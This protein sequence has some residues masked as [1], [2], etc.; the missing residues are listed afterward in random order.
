MEANFAQLRPNRDLKPEVDCKSSRRVSHDRIVAMDLPNE[1]NCQLVGMMNSER[2]KI[3]KR[4][5][6]G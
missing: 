4:N 5:V 2:Y 1:E 3:S 6:L